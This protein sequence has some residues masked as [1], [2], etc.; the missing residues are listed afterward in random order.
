MTGGM[1]RPTLL[2]LTCAVFGSACA[3]LRDDPV[4]ARRN[5]PERQ[6][7]AAQPGD[8]P[9]EESLR[10][11]R[12]GMSRTEVYRLLG[13]PRDRRSGAAVVWFYGQPGGRQ[14]LL[15]FVEGRL[16]GFDF[17]S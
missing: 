1:A 11:V 4:F 10:R 12:N 6:L 8:Y 2:L 5:I 7:D 15:T 13:E 3:P 17:G 14:L 16:Q 9:A